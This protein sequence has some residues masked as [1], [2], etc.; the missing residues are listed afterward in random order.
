MVVEVLLQGLHKQSLVTAVLLT[1][2][3]SFNDICQVVVDACHTVE[4]WVLVCYIAL[5][6]VGLPLA[7]FIDCCIVKECPRLQDGCIFGRFGHFTCRALCL[8][9]LLDCALGLHSFC[10][11]SPLLLF[12]VGECVTRELV[13]PFSQSLVISQWW[14]SPVSFLSF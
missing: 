6:V 5:V 4:I 8:G 7:E 13:E 9:R 12:G 3:F 11:Q 10:V 14:S 2:R 1:G